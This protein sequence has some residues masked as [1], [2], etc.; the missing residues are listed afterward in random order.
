LFAN[1]ELRDETGAFILNA[2]KSGE[3]E[4]YVNIEL[5]NSSF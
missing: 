1:D 2:E 3:Y 5:L 4:G